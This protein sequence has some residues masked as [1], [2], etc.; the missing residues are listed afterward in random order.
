MTRSNGLW[1]PQLLRKTKEKRRVVTC[2]CLIAA[3][4]VIRLFDLMTIPS[5]VGG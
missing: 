4:I 3:N 5:L 1:R 2:Y